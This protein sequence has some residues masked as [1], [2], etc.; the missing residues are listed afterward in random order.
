M[1]NLCLALDTLLAGPATPAAEPAPPTRDQ[2]E[3]FERKVR[4]VLVEQC[5]GCPAG[6]KKRGGLRLDSR[7][8]LLRGG[9]SG[10]AL[11]PGEPARSRIVQAIGYQGNL[12]MPPR[13]KLPDAQ[14][15]D[16]TAWVRMGAPWPGG[17]AVA[18]GG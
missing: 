15:A 5:F 12:K 9:D 4:P 3:F 13:S 1:R 17:E 7:A 14:I 10:P 6:K 2:V 8:G 16:L 18:G 11:V